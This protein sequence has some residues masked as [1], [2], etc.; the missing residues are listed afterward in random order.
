MISRHCLSVEDDLARLRQRIVESKASQKNL[1]REIFELNKEKRD[2]IGAVEVA[3]V[4][5]LPRK[6]T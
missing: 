3:K 2:L 1:N 6:R 4:E 5:L